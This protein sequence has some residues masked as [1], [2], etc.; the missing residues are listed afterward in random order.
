MCISLLALIFLFLKLYSHLY[1]FHI[2]KF[3]F[4]W[5]NS[6]FDICLR[7]DSGSKVWGRVVFEFLLLLFLVFW[8]VCL[9]GFSFG[10]IIWE[11]FTEG[12]LS[13]ETCRGSGEQGREEGK[14]KQEWGSKSL[15]SVSFFVILCNWNRTAE[16][17]LPCGKEVGFCTTLPPQHAVSG[18]SSTSYLWVER[19]PKSPKSGP[20]ERFADGVFGNRTTTYDGW[21]P[22][23]S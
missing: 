7:I 9:L 12:M 17:H 16:P 20:L 6:Y 11:C 22:Q 10:G 1:F 21:V 5:S 19:C 13:G 15:A 18:D 14:C 4:N 2:L 8:F 3:F 23:T